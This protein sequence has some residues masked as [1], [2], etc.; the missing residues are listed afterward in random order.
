VSS[1]QSQSLHPKSLHS[2]EIRT[3]SLQGV[4]SLHKCG[5]AIFV[6]IV[7]NYKQGLFIVLQN[8]G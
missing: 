3:I 6:C 4:I 2:Y 8:F 7:I 1:L 5:L